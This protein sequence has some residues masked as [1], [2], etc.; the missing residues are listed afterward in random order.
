VRDEV[1]ARQ[2]D[3]AEGKVQPFRATADVRDNE[4]KVRIPAG[5]SLSDPEILK[6]DW[7]VDGVQGK[8]R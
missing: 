7:L 6:I 1:L 4:G 5:K 2:K 8:A 3:I